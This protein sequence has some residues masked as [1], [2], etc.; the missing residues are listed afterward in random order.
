MVEVLDGRQKNK[1]FQWLID[2]P[3]CHNP[4]QAH[5]N[6]SLKFHKFCD[7]DLQIGGK[8]SLN[9]GTLRQRSKM[10]KRIFS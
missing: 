8:R 7:H 5:D 6:E 9:K 10:K 3:V 2:N 4:V 1:M